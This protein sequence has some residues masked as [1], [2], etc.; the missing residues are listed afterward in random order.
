LDYGGQ[1]ESEVYLGF[2][3]PEPIG[4]KVVGT[5]VVECFEVSPS[6][7]FSNA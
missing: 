3:S 4:I 5:T 2:I 6:I 1:C 7:R